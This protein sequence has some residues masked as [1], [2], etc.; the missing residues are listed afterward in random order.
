LSDDRRF[1]IKEIDTQKIVALDRHSG[2]MENEAFL[3]EV[4]RA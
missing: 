4:C 2:G 3:E 1:T